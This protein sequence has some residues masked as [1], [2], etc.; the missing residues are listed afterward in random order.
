[1]SYLV[2]A[3]KWRPQTFEEVVGQKAVTQTLTNALAANR[4][5]HAYLFSGPRGVGKTSAARILAKAL[6][7]EGGVSRDPCNACPSCLDITQGR[8]LDVIEVDGA[9]NRGIDEIRELRENVRFSP[10]RARYKVIVIDEV[11]MLTEPA[12]NALL[13]TLEEPPSRVVFVLATTEAHKVPL[14]IVSR[15]QR[16]EFHRI[17]TAE[18][19]QRLQ[20]MAQEEGVAI[21]PESLQMIARGAEGSL[22][23]A[24]SLL[25]QVVS[26]SGTQVKPEDVATILG[27]VDRHKVEE[28]VGH[29]LDGEGSPLLQVVEDFCL[30]GHDLRL[31]CVG[32]LERIRD[33]M[34][35]RVA[36]SPDS[37]LGGG[38]GISA[39][40]KGK[41]AGLSFP[42]LDRLLQILMQAEVEM[43][44]SP[45]P[46]FVL[47]MALLRMVEGRKLQPV[48]E[49]WKRLCQMEKKL[50]RDTAT[51]REDVPPREP[52]QGPSLRAGE[53]VPEEAG[54]DE[55]KE[56]T[57]AS[58]GNEAEPSRNWVADP[59]WAEFKR[60]VMREKVSLA[61]LLE[62]FSSVSP[63]GYSLM[64][65][66]DGTNSYLSG[67]L[68]DQGSRR[69]LEG[70]I[71]S[72][73]G[74]SLRIRYEFGK[75]RAE[76]REIFPSPEPPEPD[77]AP[78]SAPSVH[79]VV[80]KALEVFEG[81]VVKRK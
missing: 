78:S 25:D 70:A 40:L 53:G 34:V 49:I 61:P 27:I 62:Y 20:E 11:H 13:K 72:V 77:P 67:V 9:S 75:N 66:V 47:E 58:G 45:Y 8:H 28:A 81:R 31:F 76:R 23:D 68:E 65:Q 69:I 39:S 2:F 30:A 46:R 32:L 16:F 44:R 43:R 7:C 71:K 12:F 36:A 55:T 54:K 42:E 33:L 5:A 26:Y 1:M 41:A 51:P 4:I 3:R 17:G 15:C 18:M 64:I 10:Y 21:D 56:A 37:L 35:I 29:I 22:R 63:Q 73:F 6:N 52:T 60:A 74:Q 57:W 59:R 48:E 38:G 24:Q 50:S 79:S 19:T 80:E 14:T